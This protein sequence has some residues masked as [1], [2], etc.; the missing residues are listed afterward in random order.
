MGN[1][2]SFFISLLVVGGFCACAKFGRTL[3]EAGLIGEKEVQIFSSFDKGIK[4]FLPIGYEEERIIGEALAIETVK[5]Y[6]GLYRDRQTM[7]Y[8]NLVG[9][10]LAQVSDR[11]NMDYYF[12]VLNTMEPNAFTAPGGYIFITRGILAMSG[13][14]AELAGVLAHE[15]AHVTEKHILK[16][17]RRSRLLASI[18]ELSTATLGEDPRFF[19]SIMEEVNDK[20]FTKGLDQSME[21]EADE[22]G[23]E[24]AYRL[25]YNPS[26]LLSFQEKLEKRLGK[27]PSVFFQ[28][29]PSITKRIQ[30]E[31]KLLREKYQNA[32]NYPLL[33][34]RYRKFVVF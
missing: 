6:G 23:I 3:N 14:E 20:L 21:Y 16:T 26:G 12:A 30:R 4:S 9:R 27:E 2:R 32:Q 1:K 24:Y 15:I 25:G 8:V 22:L 17:L 31:R 18:S 29:H 28:T 34:A 11:A 13:S 19:D 10:A 5:R 7:R 33:A